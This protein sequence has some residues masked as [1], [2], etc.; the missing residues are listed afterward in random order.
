MTSTGEYTVLNRI[1]LV[2]MKDQR[3]NQ[4]EEERKHQEYQQ[5]LHLA[6]ESSNMLNVE[7]IHREGQ[8][9]GNL[10]QPAPFQQSRREH[11]MPNS[12]HSQL[13]FDSERIH[14]EGKVPLENLDKEA[15]WT[16]L[17]EVRKH[18]SSLQESLEE[19]EAEIEGYHDRETELLRQVAD[20]VKSGNIAEADALR[21]EKKQILELYEEAMEM[22]G[23]LRKEIGE[24]KQR[25]EQLQT[26]LEE[27]EA[28]LIQQRNEQNVMMVD[29][30]RREH[31][32]LQGLFDE[33]GQ[34]QRQA[35]QFQEQTLGAYGEVHRNT[36]YQLPQ[37]K[38]DQKR[39]DTLERL[40]FT[41]RE[42]NPGHRQ[43]N[44]EGYMMPELDSSV[45]PSAH[46]KASQ[47]AQS[48]I[49]K[50]TREGRTEPELAIVQPSRR[51][52][53]VKFEK[54]PWP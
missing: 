19:C 41:P 13:P 43:F 12:S 49:R 2:Q 14:G 11:S 8:S 29:M 52:K 53:T 16:E 31:R 38:N 22:N 42:G 33:I 30:L 39:R 15:L 45:V 20:A 25:E 21:E 6:K 54:I 46:S 50:T 5:R 9:E 3:W 37:N 51:G 32:G 24:R 35:G 7:S 47:A 1:Q 4:E 36:T 10:R 26:L 27:K 28:Q 40:T 23:R 17:T 34:L 44:E 48:Y 18:V